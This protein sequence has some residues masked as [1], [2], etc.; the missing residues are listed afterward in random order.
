MKVLRFIAVG[1]LLGASTVTISQE[2]SNG[3]Y[4]YT[5]NRFNLN[6]A[7]AGN[8]GNISAL[9]N[10]KSY[11]GTSNGAPKNT[12]FGVQG[13]INEEQGVGLRILSDKRGAYEVGKYDLAYSHQIKIDEQSDLRF[14]VSAGLTRRMLNS[15]SIN[16]VELLNQADPTLASG[17]FDESNFIAGIGLVYDYE[18]LQFGLSSPHLIESG[19]GISEF[20]VGTISYIYKIEETPFSISPLLIYQNL[21][22]IDNQYDFLLKTEYKEKAWVQLGYQSN[23]NLNFGLGF[24]IGPLGIGY[25]YEMTNSDLSNISSGSNE[26]I[27]VV[28]LK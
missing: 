26:I 20:W 24:D 22:E 15:G 13:A 25:S 9:L 6:P 4:N 8:R 17:Y 28:S 16:N 14:G 23:N 27:I 19:E 10:T 21:P 1:L 18:N 11:Q 3:Y 2:L 12:F 5:L 7:F